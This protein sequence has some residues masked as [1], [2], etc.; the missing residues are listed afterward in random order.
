MGGSNGV[1]SPLAVSDT[2][3][4]LEL[5]DRYKLGR[6][7]GQG[8]F[9]IV[10]ECTKLKTK[11][12]YAVKM[13]DKAETPRGE[14]T[15][16]CEMLLRVAHPCVIKLHE[17]FDEKVFVCMVMDLMG[18]GDLISGMQDHWEKKGTIPWCVSQ[19]V[20]KQMLT[21]I[22]W[23]HSK[24]T[25]HRDVKGDNFLMDRPQIENPGCRIYLSDF[26]SVV[27][28]KPT[29]RLREAVGTK[30]YWSPEFYALSYSLKV[31]IWATGV[32]MY[33][34][35][36]GRF[37]FKNKQDAN[38]KP[39]KLPGALPDE[40]R[41]LIC[42]M[43][44]KKEEERTSAAKA[45][46][47]PYV[48]NIDS[49]AGQDIQ[50]HDKDF[51]SDI[52]RDVASAAL[53]K[54]RRELVE[55]LHQANEQ[56]RG[57]DNESAGLDHQKKLIKL[58][59]DAFTVSDRSHGTI[60]YE[61]WPNEK[62]QKHD[63]I[64]QSAKPINN[65]DVG[66]AQAKT[67]AI[68]RLLG[69]HNISTSDFGK[70]KAKKVQQ[71]VDEINRGV[72]R[73]MLDATQ[74]KKLVRVVKIVLLR[75]YVRERGNGKRLLIMTAERTPDGRTKQMSQLPGAKQDPHESG[76][77]TAKRILADRLGMSDCKVRLD[78]NVKE[79]FEEEEDSPSYPGLRTVYR[80]LI[81]EGK[82]SSSDIPAL[83]KLN[84]KG[85]TYSSEDSAGESRSFT[86]LTESQ[87]ASKRIIYQAPADGASISALVRP[88]VGFKEEE[89]VNFLVNNDVDVT[90]F[91]QGTNRTLEEFSAELTSGE[92]ALQRSS[93]GK[94]I[95]NVDVVILHITRKSDGYSLVQVQ[96]T[97]HG[98]T[99]TLNRFPATKMSMDENLFHAAKRLIGQSLRMGE[100]AVCID[101]EGCTHVEEESQSDAYQGLPTRYQKRFVRATI[102]EETLDSAE[103]DE[104]EHGA[105]HTTMRPRGVDGDASRIKQLEKENQSLQRKVQDLE[106]Q[107]AKLKAENKSLKSRHPSKTSE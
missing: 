13:V 88:P 1:Q 81:F 101:P 39:V 25:I 15:R 68:L 32:V 12:K 73:L 66:D 5:L 54:R 26:G 37:P 7:L 28:C 90:Q 59:G 10:Y 44:A 78:F 27:P 97:L 62:I 75:V 74:Y 102:P 29:E 93:N 34:L 56:K 17:I 31:D 65:E 105:R 84:V 48:A 22:A 63:M 16:E 52:K 36:C 60:R 23:L 55:R 58:T 94:L 21:A 67:D 50:A 107:M 3:K 106:L 86:W 24:D 42:A 38:T 19:N 72:S 85:G 33:G 70:G 11:V 83:R 76:M 18:G 71:L 2:G 79:R 99:K 49:A 46:Q 92:A 35:T 20:G 98:K 64:I 41:K 40:G 103:D 53:D 4:K 69:E 14:I 82:V 9:G 43:L 104:D 57:T 95:R 96:Q 30:L 61:W 8:A 51:K 80:K 89:L 45:L 47:M 91:G 77:E 100:N 87:C 6:E